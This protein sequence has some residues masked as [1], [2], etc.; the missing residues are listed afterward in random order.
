MPRY[1]WIVFCLALSLAPA[2]AVANQPHP[3]V[4]P[5]LRALLMHTVSQ[6]DS[7]ADAFDAEVWLLDMSTRLR[8]YLPDE[9]ERLRFLQLV[10]REARQAGLEPDLV[11]AVI[12]VE[13]LF[14]RYA[15]SRVGAQ[16]VMQVMPFWKNELGRPDDNLIDLATN[17]RYGC[18]I[19]KYYLDLEKGDLR[20]ALARYNGSLGSH[21]Y[22]DK[23]QEYWY[24][25]WYVKD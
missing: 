2:A 15:L 17:L 10:H 22:P 7:F 3:P 12:H 14:D 18:T 6:A 19:L 11:L 20:R 25:Y 24:R 1:T 21:R 23:V 4:D 16:G 9:A 13:S 5:D 8:R